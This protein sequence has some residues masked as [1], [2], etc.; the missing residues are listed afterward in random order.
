MFRMLSRLFI[1]ALLSPAGK[2]LTS[3]LLLG[4][5]IVFL[6]LPHVVSWDRCGTFHVSFLDLCR[7]SYFYNDTTQRICICVSAE[8]ESIDFTW[9][10]RIHPCSLF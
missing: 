3:W 8:I 7:L 2:G 5:F 9:L 6:L 10:F 4:M 1:A